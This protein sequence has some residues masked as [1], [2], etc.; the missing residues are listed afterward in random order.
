[1][2]VSTLHN[3]CRA[4]CC[5]LH[6]LFAGHAAGVL[7]ACVPTHSSMCGEYRAAVTYPLVTTST[8]HTGCAQAKPLCTT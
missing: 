4:N 3:C 5:L 6:N 7:G 1:M 2:G 8:T